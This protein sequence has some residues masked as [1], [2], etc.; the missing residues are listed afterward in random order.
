MIGNKEYTVYMFQFFLSQQ[1][2]PST[3]TTAS[4][5]SVGGSWGLRGAILYLLFVIA[6]YI[7]AA[8]YSKHY[9]GNLLY[10]LMITSY[11]CLGHYNTWKVFVY[12]IHEL[13]IEFIDFSRSHLQVGSVKRPSEDSATPE[14]K[15]TRSMS[16]VS[17]SGSSWFPY[18]EVLNDNNDFSCQSLILLIR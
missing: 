10:Y 12:T 16:Q 9:K 7:A 18:K 8:N 17:G 4:Q 13:P 15:R 2:E 6:C 5:V 1:T 11:N 14:T 3:P